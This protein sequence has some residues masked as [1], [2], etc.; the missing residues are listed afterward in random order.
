MFSVKRF[1]S[2]SLVLILLSAVF[3]LITAPSA[4]GAADTWTAMT[5]GTTEDLY[6][7]WG[8]SS[9]DVFAAGN[10]G[11]ILHYNGSAWSAM[12]SGTSMGLQGLWGSPAGNIFVVGWSGTI[13]HFD[14]TS[15]TPMTSGTSYDLYAVWGNSANSVFAV[16][17]MET[18]CYWNGSAWSTMTTPGEE[19][20]LRAVWGTAYNNVYAVGND[21]TIL[22]WDG[23][24]WSPMT[25]GTSQTLL[26]IWGS[27]ASDIWAGGI[28]QSSL[29]HFDGSSWSGGGMP[30]LEYYRG[31]WG[32][33]ASNVYR[34]GNAMM[35]AGS[36]DR[37]NGSSWVDVTIPSSPQLN[38]IWG[39]CETDIFAVGNSGTILHYG[40]GCGN[41]CTTSASLNTTLGTVELGASGACVSGAAWIATKDM[42]CSS[43]SGCIFPYGMFSFDSGNIAAGQTGRITIHFPNPIPLAVK[44]YNCV[45][46]NMV[47]ISSQVSRINEYNLLLTITSGGPYI[48]GAC[49]VQSMPQSS[50]PSLPE[51]AKAPVKLANISIKSASLSSTKVTPGTPV[52]V[53]ANIANTSAVNGTSMIKV[54]VNGQE[55]ASQGVAVNSGSTSRV[56]FNVSR[57][58]PG[59]YTVYVGGTQAG[60]FTVEQF[61]PDTILFISGALVFFALVIGVIYMIRRQLSL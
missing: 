20:A 14:G 59:T 28:L 17:G 22:H 35:G 9:S 43:P 2:L 24:S 4:A 49:F 47:D 8:S 42:P 54:Y 37:Y 29:V 51:A 55:D 58:E 32:T 13:L 39:Q 36:I 12:A 21:G 18:I 5:S 45:N 19:L 30:N 25:S 57:N 46:G 60:S 40:S 26:A 50:S 10:N 38:G 23:T 27:S 33:S 7:V 15:W 31:M 11:T 1:F 52:I 3:P 61:T 41:G 6:S 44:Y 16:G 56:T 34:V 48:F 53:T